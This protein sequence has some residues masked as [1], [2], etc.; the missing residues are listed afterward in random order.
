VGVDFTI[1]FARPLHVRKQGLASWNHY[2]TITAAVDFVCPLTLF[3]LIQ[4]EKQI[5]RL[6]GDREIADWIKVANKT[7][8]S[9]K[10]EKV[11]CPLKSP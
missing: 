8:T 1:V 3:G 2:L 7:S 5:R 6:P 4:P 10:Y 9:G 11:T